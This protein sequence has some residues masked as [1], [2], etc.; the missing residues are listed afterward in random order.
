MVKEKMQTSIHRHKQ[1]NFSELMRQIKD[2][3]NR[4]P[5]LLF[6]LSM[7]FHSNKMIAG[8]ILLSL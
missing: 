6:S 3:A 5:S 4:I 8:K 1:R 7:S 2:G